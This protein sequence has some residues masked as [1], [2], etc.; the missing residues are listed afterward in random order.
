MWNWGSGTLDLHGFGGNPP[1]LSASVLDLPRACEF[2]PNLGQ[3]GCQLRFFSWLGLGRVS[4]QPSIGLVERG[5]F[6]VT[7]P[8]QAQIGSFSES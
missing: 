8:N 6:S 7:F 5:I 2:G 4:E 1:P 3:C